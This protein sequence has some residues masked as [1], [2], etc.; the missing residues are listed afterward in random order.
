[1]KGFFLLLFLSINT[2]SQNVKLTELVS[3]HQNSSALKNA[4][5]SVYAE[6]ADSRK[7]IIDHN[8]QFALAPASGLKL[9]TTAAALELLGPDYKFYTK[10]FTNGKIKS[11]TLLGD[12]VLVAGGDPTFGSDLV[13]GSKSL[14]DVISLIT[15]AVFNAGI[16]NIKGNIVVLD[17]LFDTYRIPGGW[18]WIDIGNYYGASITGMTIN[19]NLY[20][21]FFK[22]GNK[23]TELAEVLRT[24]PEVPG[25]TFTNYMKTGRVGSGDN[26]Y[27]YAA[28]FQFNAT[29][30]GTI[31][32][33]VEEFSIKGAIPDPP[34]FAAQLLKS[35]LEKSGI[36]ISGNAEVINSDYSL[37][38][39][40]L[41]YTHESPPVKDIVFIVNK[42]S[43]NLYAEH[44]LRAIATKNSKKGSFYEGADIIKEFLKKNGITTD[45]FDLSDGSGLSRSNTITTKMMVE[46][47]NK[48]RAKKYFSDFYNSLGIVGDTSD[49]SSYRNMGIGTEL[50][51]NARIKSGVI[52]RV[53]GYSGYL[54]DKKERLII[55]SMIANN[56]SGSGSGISN[57]H[58]ELMIELAKLGSGE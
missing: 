24:E 39:A 19:D 42:K 45:G 20:Q 51:R 26:G 49:I 18:N 23:V 11:G 28:P 6:Y 57:I 54:R 4:Q 32:A 14:K 46:L 29:L 10:L 50:E 2:F 31:P 48:I 35:E 12:I 34:L 43:F 55:F 8:S 38:D 30:R 44:L 7:S 1:L 41:I 27:I 13:P 17:T 25:L 5:W 9:F 3:D 37:R 58:K 21:L 40:G 36:K 52:N 16:K 47:L 15:D 22:P 56:F 33:G 53:R